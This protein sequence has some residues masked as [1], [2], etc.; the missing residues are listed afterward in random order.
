[1]D[2]L[3]RLGNVREARVSGEALLEELHGG[4]LAAD[5]H[6]GHRTRHAAAQ[7]VGRILGLL[8]VHREVNCEDTSNVECGMW[9]VKFEDNSNV[10]LHEVW[11]HS[12]EDS[13][14]SQGVVQRCNDELDQRQTQAWSLLRHP[15]N[16]QRNHNIVLSRLRL[17]HGA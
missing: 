2:L 12:P 3:R 9:N 14:F 15:H 16:T 11:I 6:G 17:N 4:A 13:K 8:R 7:E 1:M 5:E 10:E